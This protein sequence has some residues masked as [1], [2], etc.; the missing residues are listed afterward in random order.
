[1]NSV[2]GYSEERNLYTSRF[3]QRFRG[4][5]GHRSSAPVQQLGVDN[6]VLS[7][8]QET[9][10]VAH[11]HLTSAETKEAVQ[12]IAEATGTALGVGQKDES[13]LRTVREPKRAAEGTTLADAN[14]TVLAEPWD[15]SDVDSSRAWTHAGPRFQAALASIITDKVNVAVL[16]KWRIEALRLINGDRNVFS[17]EMHIRLSTA[18]S[19]RILDLGGHPVW[20]YSTIVDYPTSTIHVAGPAE[21]P[22]SCSHENIVL[23]H[24]DSYTKLPFPDD[25]FD[26]IQCRKL[27]VCLRKDE[28]LPCLAEIRRILKPGGALD[29]CI[30]DANPLNPTPLTRKAD[31]AVKATLRR[32]NFL[33]RP[34]RRVISHLHT[35]GYEDITRCWLAMPT[36]GQ[37]DKVGAVLYLLVA[38]TYG[39]WV[40]VQLGS[41]SERLTFIK[42]LA[43][44][45]DGRFAL[46]MLMCSAR[47]PSLGDEA[48]ESEEEGEEEEDSA[49]Q[50]LAQMYI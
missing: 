3:F 38:Q 22:E 24:L 7:L 45:T 47:K 28:W 15:D 31:E 4:Q 21:N 1:M 2:G 26:L 46:P 41:M 20:A 48:D 17:R 29:L 14:A 37:R 13:P 50:E 12:V 18:T 25:Y 44:G 43:L 36:D 19:S 11:G 9:P 5:K 42:E 35:T 10:A 6:G 16:H 34:S 23:T 40:Q 30:F 8:R 27:S 33:T 39:L 32:G 49:I